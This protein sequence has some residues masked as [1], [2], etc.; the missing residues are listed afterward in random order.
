METS[1]ATSP[2]AVL[3]VRAVEEE[4]RRRRALLEHGA[5]LVAASLLW[6]EEEALVS[7]LRPELRA[8]ITSCARVAPELRAAYEH[9]PVRRRARGGRAATRACARASP[10]G[11][12]AGG[13]C[14]PAACAAARAGPSPRAA[15]ASGAASLQLRLE[16]RNSSKMLWWTWSTFSGSRRAPGSLSASSG[17][18]RLRRPSANCKVPRYCRSIRRGGVRGSRSPSAGIVL[19][20][21]TG[22]QVLD[23]SE[24]A[25]VRH[26]H[27]NRRRTA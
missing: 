9:P 3:A 11:A 1:A 7:E 26:A 15:A 21:T 2:I 25:I 24:A 10:P 23:A 18:R 8:R 14:A 27:R 17:A 16:A 19:C 4:R 12:R 5:E 13:R 22:R 20:R 6:R